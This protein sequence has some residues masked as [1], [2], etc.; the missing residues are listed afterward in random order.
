MNASKFS[1]LSAL[2][3]AILF[4]AMIG[5]ANA[6]AK[7]Q[8]TIVP[9]TPGAQPGLSASG[10]SIKIDKTPM[11]VSGKIKK[12]V[13]GAGNLVTTDGT[14]SA[15]DYKVEVD[16]VCAATAVSD[17]VTVPVELKNGNG[18]FKQAA[19]ALCGTAGDGAGV[20]ITGVR[21][22]DAGGSLIGVGGVVE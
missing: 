1:W 19:S 10:S 4:T 6:G 3:I 9:V 21:V 8:T 5:S 20:G 17:T 7:Y 13:D 18:T 12:V 2:A 15:D 16:R 11:V 22:K 14:P